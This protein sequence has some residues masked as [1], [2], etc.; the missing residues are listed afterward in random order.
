MH[1]VV[2]YE[3]IVDLKTVVLKHMEVIYDKEKDVL[4]YDR[5]LKDGPGTSMYGLEVCKSLNLPRDFLEDAYEIRMKYYPES[6]SILSRKQSSYNSKKIV[7]MCEKCHVNVGAEV[8]HLQY[9]S[10]ADKHGNIQT[11]DAVFNKNH[12][13]NLMTLCEGCH[14]EMHRNEKDTKKGSRKVKTT[15]GGQLKKV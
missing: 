6:Q 3:E 8:H 14:T 12:L 15:N 13:A 11:E 2:H 5:K 1:E 4:V 10:L 9:Q 7:N